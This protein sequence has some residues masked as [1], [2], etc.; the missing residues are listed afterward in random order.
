[1]D[2][3]L[4]RFNVVLVDLSLCQTWAELIDAADRRGLPIGVADAWIAA[5]AFSL[6]VPL[7]T[8]NVGDYA[9]VNG[10]TVLTADTT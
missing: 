8:N 4:Q 9:S 3:Y 7:I 5:T 10:L 1:L 2:R 6:S